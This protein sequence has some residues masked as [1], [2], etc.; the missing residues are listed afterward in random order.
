VTIRGLLLRFFFLYVGLYAGL[1]SAFGMVATRFK[2]ESSSPL[3]LLALVIATFVCMSYR[4]VTGRYFSKSEKAAVVLG[5]FT[6]DI[7]LQFCVGAWLLAQSKSAILSMP[8]FMMMALVGCI[9]LP[10]IYFLVS[11]QGRLPIGNRG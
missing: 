1:M 11:M 2:L 9:H 4:T 8:L 5:M 10:L 6:I 3:D 7:G